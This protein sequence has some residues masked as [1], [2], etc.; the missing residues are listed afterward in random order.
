[1]AYFIRRCGDDCTR[2]ELHPDDREEIVAK[3][4]APGDAEDLCASKIEGMR[5][6]AAPPLFDADPGAAPSIKPRRHARQLV[7]K[8]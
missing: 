3:G 5:A 8:F 7:F 4:L 1:M 6:A 2:I